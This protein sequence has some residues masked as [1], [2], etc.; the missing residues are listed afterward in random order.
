MYKVGDSF[1][2]LVCITR[3]MLVYAGGL[4]ASRLVKSYKMIAKMPPMVCRFISWFFH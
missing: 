2:F 3:F 1:N 4:Y